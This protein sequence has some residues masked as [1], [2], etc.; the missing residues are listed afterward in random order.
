[1]APL[2]KPPRIRLR[3]SSLIGR[4]MRPSD[5]ALLMAWSFAYRR[6]LKREREASAPPQRVGKYSHAEPYVKPAKK[7]SKRRHERLVREAIRG[8]RRR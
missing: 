2:P 3:R 1:M 5:M 8:P 6:E 4:Y 7:L